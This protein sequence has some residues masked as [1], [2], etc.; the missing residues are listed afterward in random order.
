MAKEKRP[1]KNDF[2]GFHPSVG[3]LGNRGLSQVKFQLA[4]RLPRRPLAFFFFFFFSVTQL[5]SR[6]D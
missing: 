6:C 1:L 4:L 2:L 5:L 3:E